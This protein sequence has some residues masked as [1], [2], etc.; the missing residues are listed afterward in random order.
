[1]LQD[2]N[3]TPVKL[4]IIKSYIDKAN[5]VDTKSPMILMVS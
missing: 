3:Q 4:R 2:E 1:M 5:E